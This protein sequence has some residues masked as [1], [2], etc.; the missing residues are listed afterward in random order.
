MLLKHLCSFFSTVFVWIQWVVRPEC[1]T[2]HSSALTQRYDRYYENS[3]KNTCM[4][5]SKTGV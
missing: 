2:Q 4:Q 3:C 1:I 5:N